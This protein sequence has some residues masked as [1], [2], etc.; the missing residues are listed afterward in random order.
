MSST[1]KRRQQENRKGTENLQNNQRT[2]NKMAVTKYLSVI[3]SHVNGLNAP[4]RRHRMVE[5]TT[6]MTHAYAAYKRP[7]SGHKTHMESKGM[8]KETA[9]RLKERGPDK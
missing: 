1:Y 4:I 5:C 6:I 2:I 8:A 9:S 3:T 7:T